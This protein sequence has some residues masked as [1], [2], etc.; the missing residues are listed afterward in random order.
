MS[1]GNAF[2]FHFYSIH[3]KSKINKNKGLYKKNVL[4]M[5]Y[6]SAYDTA[7]KNK[8]EFQ[9]SGTYSIECEC[10]SKSFQYSKK[11][12]LSNLTDRHVL[13]HPYKPLF[14]VLT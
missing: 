12:A 2:S 8:K 11:V 10:L 14:I 3:C 6:D 1:K 7:K 13:G 9:L 5:K 4:S